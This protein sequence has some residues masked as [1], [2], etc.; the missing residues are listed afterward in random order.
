MS[1]PGGSCSL[2]RGEMADL[3]KGP[4]SF[5]GSL[6]GQNQTVLS[7]PGGR[8][9]QRLSFLSL[10]S[11]LLSLVPPNISH[12]PSGLLF[13]VLDLRIIL[14][15]GRSS[16]RLLAVWPQSAHTCIYS[17]CTTLCSDSGNPFHAST[18]HCTWKV[19]TPQR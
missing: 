15:E 10:L 14:Q 1:D 13:V 6:I 7:Y 16:V 19:G 12:F 8:R 17:C 3:K 4:F 5:P 2:H 11:P 9:T 18:E